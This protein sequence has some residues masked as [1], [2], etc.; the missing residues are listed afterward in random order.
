LDIR[1][2]P[3]SKKL[4]RGDFVISNFRNHE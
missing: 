2:S 1:P 4:F 3:T